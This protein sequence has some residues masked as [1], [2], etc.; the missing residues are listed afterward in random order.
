MAQALKKMTQTRRPKIG[1]MLVEFDTPGI[2]QIMKAAGCEFV[3]FDWKHSSFEYESLKRT[4]R[5]LQSPK[6]AS[7]KQRVAR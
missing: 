5:Y 6:L 3:F 7:F 1:T 2:G 4:L